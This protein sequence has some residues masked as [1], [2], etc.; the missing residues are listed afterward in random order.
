M[1][2][3]FNLILLSLMNLLIFISLAF[4]FITNFLVKIRFVENF[5]FKKDSIENV[6]FDILIN[7]ISFMFFTMAF[8]MCWL[9]YL[10]IYDLKNEPSGSFYLNYPGICLAFLVFFIAVKEILLNLFSDDCF[11]VVNIQIYQARFGVFIMLLVIILILQFLNICLIYSQKPAKLAVAAIIIS[12]FL[13]ILI[14]ISQ[15]KSFNQTSPPPALDYSSSNIQIGYFSRNETDLIQKGLFVKSSSIKS[16]H[17]CNLN[18]MESFKQ[19]TF[20]G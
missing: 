20:I 2:K 5:A 3:K 4:L 11:N 9:S 14:I 12:I 7:I 16:R 1:S 8:V 13:T 17:I 6:L 10:Y 18:E 19:V 15:I